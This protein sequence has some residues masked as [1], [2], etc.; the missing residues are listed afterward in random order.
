MESPF[1]SEATR[2]ALEFASL[3]AL[4]AHE[5]RTDLGR[6]HLEGL[7][8]APNLE[9]LRRRREAFEAVGRL[10]SEKALLSAFDVPLDP[11]FRRAIANDPPLSGPE[12]LELVGALEAALE[13]ASRWGALAGGAPRLRAD[14]SQ[15]SPLRAP[16][17]R[18]RRVLDARGDVRPE[19]SPRLLELGQ[20]IRTTRERIYRCLGELREAHPQLGAEEV[21]PLAGGRLV[22]RI[23]QPD[24]R[25]LPG[26]VHARSGSSR[27]VYFEPLA[28]VEDNNAMAQA[29][30]AYEREVERILN[31]LRETFAQ[32]AS[33][34]AEARQLLAELDGLEALHRF[35]ER[36]RSRLAALAEDGHFRLRA[37]RHPLLDPALASLRQAVLGQPGHT[38]PIVPLE[39]EL[40]S[41]RRL[42]VVTGPNAGGKTVALKTV[43][44]L[45]L[46]HASGF[47]IPADPG[48]ELP[49]LERLV[50][51]IGD[52][53][54]LLA[55][56]STFSGRLL[57]LREAWEARGPRA[58][59]LLD[60]LGSGTD[61]VEGGA[62]ARSL[63]EEL[64][65]T[66][67][68]GIVTTHLLELAL[69]A[70]D[71]D[72]AQPAAMEFE[73][74]R[75]LPTYR[76]RVGH[77]GRSEALAL[78]RRL[79]LPGSWI[80]R[81]EALVGSGHLEI[82]RSLDAL[83]AERGALAAARAELE[84]ARFEA[85]AATARLERE[86]ERLE[87]ERRELGRKL[88]GELETFVA[89]VQRELRTEREKVREELRRGRGEQAL[90]ETR[91]RLLRE[92]P[93]F[94]SETSRA[95]ASAELAPGLRVRHRELGWEG[96]VHARQG[97]RVELAV[98]GKR[99][100]LLASEVEPVPAGLPR[101][102]KAPGT[103]PDL[104]GSS[105]AHAELHLRGQRV[106]EALAE[107]DAFL[108]R[109]TRGPLDQVR[110]VHGH[111]T[112]RLR[113]AVREHLKRHPLVR[114]FRPGEPAEGGNGATVV[115]LFPDRAGR[116]RA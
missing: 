80:E 33:A 78:A 42:L 36:S 72:G 41:E 21:P 23:H 112:G 94:R 13:A 63:L 38:G 98:G 47:P 105:V 17:E 102:A 87:Q 16:V 83:V 75:G 97:D 34:L 106:E 27:S 35:A 61:P 56:R 9:E 19:A 71:L 104:H 76:L 64:S 1:A 109:A 68:P 88:R 22:L 40:D 100:A 70:V 25:T 44:L 79:D 28:V 114:A 52:E 66:A 46:A 3:V 53:Q 48:S 116:R 93:S 57:R 77:P 74:G 43:G 73:P 91:E 96:T 50:A 18:A 113:L 86:R 31:E 30:A 7:E 49:W 85:E 55:E 103:E 20:R 6:E 10:R 5:A 2:N 39:L 60:E 95:E 115:D 82:S 89:R 107:L 58:L 51:V 54:D 65:R 84:R 101:Q 99:I 8:P 45:A 92:A 108:D 15:L 12:I 62:L 67:T 69:A 111:G 24:T 110:I 32:A 14:W 59:V 29:Q 81:A 26:L 11:L 37:A 90:R 4:I